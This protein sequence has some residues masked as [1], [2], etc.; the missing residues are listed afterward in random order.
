MPYPTKY[1]RQY[2]F[3]SYQVSN[4]TRPLP[5]NQVN[6]DLNA[7]QQSVKEIIDFLK[8]VIR[9]DG[10]LANGSVGA[11]QLDVTFDL[12]FS[13]P[14]V[15]EPG[16]DYTDDST[17][18]YANKFWKAHIAHTSTDGFDESKWNL[19]VDFG[20]EATAAAV[21][22]AAALASKNAASVSETN[23]ANSA[24][25]AAASEVASASSAGAASDSA[26]V[27]TTK[28]SAASGSA[29]SA[30]NSATLAQTIL[31][32]F[33]TKYL[34]AKSSDPTTDNDGEAPLT[35]ALYWSTTEDA[36]KIYDG[37]AWQAYAPAGAGDVIAATRTDLKALA[38]AKYTSAFL[39]EGKRRGAWRW[40]T[41]DYAARIAADTKEGLFIKANDTASTSG[42]WV[43]EIVDGYVHSNWFGATGD[44]D[45]VGGTG[46]DDTAALQAWL[47]MCLY[48]AG[49]GYCSA[50]LDNGDYKITSG[51]KGRVYVS[52]NAQSNRWARIFPVMSAGPALSFD[53]NVSGREASYQQ[54][55]SNIWINGTY[56]TGTA[57]ALAFGLSKNSKI[58]LNRFTDFSATTVGAVQINGA[59]YALTF[60][61]NAFSDNVQH[62]GA[63]RVDGSGNFPTDCAFYRNTFD[64]SV[65]QSSLAAVL[66]RNCAGFI[67]KNNVL[68]SNQAKY[69]ILC[70]QDATAETDP[71]HVI[72]ENWFENN[73][74]TQSGSV[75]VLMAG[76]NN[77]SPSLARLAAGNIVKDNSWYG[78]PPITIIEIDDGKNCT[79]TGNREPGGGANAAL[80]VTGAQDGH[81]IDLSDMKSSCSAISIDANLGGGLVT[82]SG[83]AITDT[84]LQNMTIARNSAGSF[85][86]TFKKQP[87][88]SNYV[89]DVSVEKENLG[90]ILSANPYN[91]LVATF[92]ILVRDKSDTA[93]DPRTMWINVR[94][95][96]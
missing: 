27:A 10:R 14:T 25:G 81:K 41:G 17:V 80:I 96:G 37:A 68:Q 4:P 46:T 43:R 64:T 95:I 54:T 74:L 9:S 52:I 6:Y 93:V 28:A 26:A 88:T 32:D 24:S 82:L 87:K 91:P 61:L 62:I 39:A 78:S 3:Q 90:V 66:F 1:T 70:Y 38:T 71:N 13:L 19:I 75:D 56:A 47:D 51:L 63:D 29:T 58:F 34:G 44:F 8:G 18:L 76:T 11:N 7:V 45:A 48:A 84:K 65:S 55:V 22:A 92:S 21:S 69:L 89:V 94:G 77:A 59:N 86:C 42:A 35:G 83:T 50:W 15:W 53:Q 57:C 5:G 67:F 40:R 16:V 2:D 20:A 79:V 31:D 72:A 73:G 60:E 49:A 33:E 85:T 36:L 23:A 12:G 30:A